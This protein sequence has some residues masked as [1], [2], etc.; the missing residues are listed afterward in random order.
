VNDL[1]EENVINYMLWGYK[2]IPLGAVA[3]QNQ[4]SA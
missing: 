3:G 4:T 2:L 1:A